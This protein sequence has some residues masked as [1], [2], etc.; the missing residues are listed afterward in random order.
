[1]WGFDLLESFNTNPKALLKNTRE[2]LQRV[3]KVTLENNILQ[4]RLTLVFDAMANKTLRE[5]S[6]PTTTNI[7]TGP[8]VNVGE[9]GFELKPGLIN[10]VQANQL[11]GKS[12]KDASAHL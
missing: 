7:H 8:A 12:Y 1:M 6:A 2:K 9:D 10:L 11:N 4:R 3:P 5:Y